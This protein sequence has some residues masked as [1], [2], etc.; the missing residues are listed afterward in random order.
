[1]K[2]GDKVRFLSEVGGGKISGFQGKS[3]VLVE[4]EDGFEIPMPIS[5][6]IVIETDNYNFAKTEEKKTEKKNSETQTATSVKSALSSVD[7]DFDEDDETEPCD[8]PITFKPIPMERK[9]GDELNLSLCFIPKDP[10]RISSSDFKTYIVNE[11][12]YYMHVVYSYDDG[13]AWTMIYNGIVAPNNRVFVE[14][15][16]HSMLN[17]LE[18]IC[19][20]STAWKEDKSF[21]I[22]PAITA[23]IKIDCT[24]FYK[25]HTFQKSELFSEICWMVPVIRADKAIKPLFVDA[26]EIQSSIVSNSIKNDVRVQTSQS[27][28]HVMGKTPKAKS[29]TNGKTNSSSKST[30]NTANQILEVDLHIDKLLDTAYGMSNADLLLVQMK[31]FRRV[32]DEN[33][34][35]PGK[36]IIF[37]HGKGDG[38]LRKNI[39]QELKYRYKHCTWQ[40]ASFQQYGFGAT[41]V[42]V[43]N[44]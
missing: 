1:M 30:S 14:E 2:I 21:E 23:N 35:K 38:V 7:D 8:R 4:D 9:G 25:L 43:H 20:Q 29:R 6:V 19:L 24:K 41:Q 17:D 39:L 13:N 10:Q 36:K 11:S 44:M 22:K 31:E 12:N 27:T 15:I 32:M 16:D 28:N 40:D 3:T 37:I 5:E 18:H 42:T 33:K 26:E 34:M